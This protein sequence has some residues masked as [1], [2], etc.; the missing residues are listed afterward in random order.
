MGA[1]GKKVYV[2]GLDTKTNTVQIGTE[3]ALWKTGLTA[4]DVI[5]HGPSSHESTM[6]VQA[7]VR[8]SDEMVPGEL[9]WDEK[10]DIRIMFDRPK[11]AITPGQSVV[12]YDGDDVLGG[13]VISSVLG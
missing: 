5:W 12:F 11:R 10:G 13:G 2:T 4:S 9:S 8:Y 6:R 1:H 3:E 7:K